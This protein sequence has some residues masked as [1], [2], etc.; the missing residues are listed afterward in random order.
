MTDRECDRSR[1]PLWLSLGVWAFVCGLTTSAAQ[2]QD[3]PSG[4]VRLSDIAPAIRQDI[5]YAGSFNFMGRRSAGYEAPQCVLMRAAAEA[6]SRAQTALAKEGFGLKVYDCYRPVRAVRGFVDWTRSAGDTAMKP[7]FYPEQDKS[8]LL[9]LGYIAGRSTH[10]TGYA[11]DIGL[12]R[13]DEPA[14]PTP[15]SGGRCD[16]PFGERARES[17]VDLGTAFDCFSRKS[18]TAYP[19]LDAKARENRA[20]LTRALEREGFR[21]YVREWWHFTYTGASG[22]KAYDFVIR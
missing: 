22:A 10:S 6:L 15:S 18:A 5:R 19:T 21:N 9:A 16:G 7:V 8:E 3:M 14:L 13:A 11:V 17:G 12:V 1:R 4:F 20:R 2:A